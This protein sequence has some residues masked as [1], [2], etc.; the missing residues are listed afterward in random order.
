MSSLGVFK[1]FGSI[2]ASFIYQL[3][4]KNLDGTD[5]AKI[6]YITNYL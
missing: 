1:S 3:R 5:F 2:A 4:E 6:D